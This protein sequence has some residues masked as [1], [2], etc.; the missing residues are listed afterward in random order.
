[1]GPRGCDL[2]SQ[3]LSDPIVVIDSSEIREGKLEELKTALEELAAFVEANEADPIACN[4]YFDEPSK[5]I[6]GCSLGFLKTTCS[7]T[8]HCTPLL[9]S[10]VTRSVL[11]SV[12]EREEKNRLC[13]PVVFSGDVAD[14]A[15][16]AYPAMQG[17]VARVRHEAVGLWSAASRLNP[18]RAAFDHIDDAN[19]AESLAFM[20]EHTREA[21][22]NLERTATVA[23]RAR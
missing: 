2:T 8:S 17:Q 7:K 14:L 16:L 3:S 19:V 9:T 5:R 1:V 21:L 6:R 12:E 20:H 15:R 18:A 4:N 23:A 10:S 22:R 11:T 13:P